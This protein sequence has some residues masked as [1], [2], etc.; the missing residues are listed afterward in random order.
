MISTLCYVIF[1]YN[2]N[3]IIKQ[4]YLQYVIP[5]SSLEVISSKPELYFLLSTTS[6]FMIFFLYSYILCYR[7]FYL[8]QND[9]NS[10]GLSFVYLKHILN[11]I[12]NPNM[13]I[14]EYEVNRGIMW[15]FST[16]LMLKMYCDANDIK[17][18][19]I[20]IH[21][22]L[23]SII[24]HIFL[25]PFKKHVIYFVAT[26]ICSIS[27]L[28]F[29]KTLYKYKKLAFT[30]LYILIWSIFM[31]INVLEIT[32]LCSPIYI[33]ALYNLADTLC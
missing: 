15:V 12:I 16:P 20:N 11:I 32:Q 22:H 27:A 30:N 9:R 26:I 3:E 24:T 10:L 14:M 5:S 4:I 18:L 23:I 1:Y 6:Y 31:L 21:Y 7:I 13:S 2:I 29:L 19:D 8:K 28:L 17:L 25:I 33:H